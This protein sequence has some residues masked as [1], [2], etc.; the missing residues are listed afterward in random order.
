M[1]DH[2]PIH[3][4]AIFRTV[5]FIVGRQRSFFLDSRKIQKK[6]K[7]RTFQ[8]SKFRLIWPQKKL[9]D[10]VFLRRKSIG[11]FNSLSLSFSITHTHSLSFSRQDRKKFF[12][13]KNFWDSFS[14][15]F[16]DSWNA[17]LWLRNVTSEAQNEEKERKRE[18][19]NPTF[20]FQFSS[21]PFFS[22]LF[23]NNLFAAVGKKKAIVDNRWKIR[24]RKA[25]PRKNKAKRTNWKLKW[26]HFAWL[27][28][29]AFVSAI[30]LS[31]SRFLCLC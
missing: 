24:L 15:F 23:E 25:T 29:T 13:C 30:A 4:P 19:E 6:F 26:Q 14:S 5:R 18:E 11:T 21:I 31:L 28:M 12:L 10:F 9:L 3:I 27:K 1:V 17:Q 16:S 22:L 20:N 8:G 2:R 7:Q